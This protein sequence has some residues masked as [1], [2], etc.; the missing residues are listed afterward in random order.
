MGR[1]RAQG[2]PLVSEGCGDLLKMPRRNTNLYILITIDFDLLKKVQ[3]YGSVIIHNL[4]PINPFSHGS[5]Q[6]FPAYRATQCEIKK[7]F[8]KMC[9]CFIFT[10]IPLF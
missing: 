5:S 6:G 8:K 4:H 2:R 3:M 9:S 10:C 1:K 7:I